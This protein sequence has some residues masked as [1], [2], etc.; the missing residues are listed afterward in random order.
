[1]FY[2]A[3]FFIVIF[4][5]STFVELNIY[6]TFVEQTRIMTPLSKAEEEV[7]QI[8]W[9]KE[10]AIMMDILEA[11]PE[12]KPANTTIATLLKRIQDKGF[13]SYTQVGRSREYF[14]LV[15]KNA[16]FSKQMNGMIKKFFN[17]SASQFASFFTEEANMSKEELEDLKKLIDNQ[18]KNKD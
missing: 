5:I 3:G 1:M 6:S 4:F 17:N 12:P 15:K 10:K 2:T 9:K 16:Y 7:M 13:V 18:I 14:P 8:L 11:Y